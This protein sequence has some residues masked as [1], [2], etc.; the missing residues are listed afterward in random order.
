M[1]IVKYFFFASLLALGACG[2]DDNN[3]DNSNIQTHIYKKN[4]KNKKRTKKIPKSNHLLFGSEARSLAPRP[5]LPLSISAQKRVPR[6]LG[7]L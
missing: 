1:K 7:G 3:K 5:I 4:K 6:M 2:D